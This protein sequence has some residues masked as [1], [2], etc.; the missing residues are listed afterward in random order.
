M[1]GLKTKTRGAAILV[2]AVAATLVLALSGCT[3]LNLRNF[4]EQK[5]QEYEL[6]KNPRPILALKDGAAVVALDGTVTMPNTIFGDPGTKTLTIENQG[7]LPLA[8]SGP[9]YVSVTGGAGAAA[10]S[11]SQPGQTTIPAGS[12]V[13]FDVIFTP[14]AADTDYA[15]TLVINSN[16]PQNGAYGFG[17][18][19]HSTQWHGSKAVVSSSTTVYGSPQIAVAGST[20]YVTYV[21]TNGINLSKS[22]DGGKTWV[23]TP[24]RVSPPTIT[25]GTNH[26]IVE[27]TGGD[28]HLFYYNSS[29]NV[30]SYNKWPVGYSAIQSIWSSAA[31]DFQVWQGI[32]NASIVLDSGKVY[33]C[34][35]DH[36]NLR[37]RV[38]VSTDQSNPAAFSF[39]VYDVT[40]S[41][42]QTGGFY[43]SMKIK[44][45][46]IYISYIDGKSIKLAKA[47]TSSL[48]SWNYYPV[49]TDAA[50]SIGA[51]TLVADATKGHIIYSVSDGSSTLYHTSSTDGLGMTTWASDTTLAGEN[52]NQSYP[53]PFILAGSSLY[54]LYNSSYGGGTNAVRLAVSTDGGASWSKQWIDTQ[55]STSSSNIAIAVSGSN[56]FTAY[57]TPSSHPNQYSITIKKSL[58]GGV[59]W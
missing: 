29:L 49:Y 57:S 1:A 36:V 30:V 28:F 47:S 31:L 40:N 23:A 21:D 7:N 22:T 14:P 51:A 9:P 54:A 18:S 53:V 11:L 52:A 20:V 24:F 58:D 59:T 26:S 46:D 35:W 3:P 8:L 25:A 12:S 33:L 4:V 43:P 19:G 48:S 32:Q 17:S 6:A 13:P 34:Y 27:T 5:V 50:Y 39:T 41:P 56:V 44:S 2:A 37:L 10:Y 15:A 55:L 42:T 16:D 45:G 38:A